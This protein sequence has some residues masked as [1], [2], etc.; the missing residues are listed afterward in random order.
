MSYYETWALAKTGLDNNYIFWPPGVVEAALKKSGFETMRVNDVV[1]FKIGVGE[2]EFRRLQE[3]ETDIVRITKEGNSGSAAAVD[4]AGAEVS[5][6]P[7]LQNDGIS[8]TNGN[9]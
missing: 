3:A 1:Y 7:T 9:T 8:D 6:Q 4:D 5:V 2:D